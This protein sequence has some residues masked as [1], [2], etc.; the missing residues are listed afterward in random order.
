[1]LRAALRR[2]RAVATGV[3]G[4]PWWCSTRVIFWLL[5]GH[6][7]SPPAGRGEGAGVVGGLGRLVRGDGA[8]SSVVRPADP[9]HR[10]HPETRRQRLGSGALLGSSES[11]SS[12]R[13]RCGGAPGAARFGRASCGA[14]LLIRQRR[15]LAVQALA[16][17]PPWVLASMEDGRRR[18]LL[19]R[20]V[21]AA[22]GRAWRGGARRGTWASPSRT[23]CC[24]TRCSTS[25]SPQLP[26]MPVQ[27][28]V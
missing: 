3:L 10:H 26:A 7:D 23:G 2:H 15:K 20:L 18:R 28:E 24:T 14:S 22:R 8:V 9:G 27:Q 1:M 19:G 17:T 12:T 16:G 6:L 5:L 11:M 13:P 4:V 25:P 21:V